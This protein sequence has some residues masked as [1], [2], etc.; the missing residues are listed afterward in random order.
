MPVSVAISLS[1]G[2]GVWQSCLSCSWLRRAAWG[3]LGKAGSGQ[4][5]PR[6]LKPPGCRAPSRGGQGA[7]E[8]PRVEE[9][10]V[11]TVSRK[12]PE[13]VP[14]AVAAADAGE[15]SLTWEGGCGSALPRPRTS[16]EPLATVHSRGPSP[17]LLPARPCGN[18][19]LVVPGSHPQPSWPWSPLPA[20]LL[21]GPQGT[22]RPVP[23]SPQ[24]RDGLATLC[25]WRCVSSIPN[26]PGG[27]AGHPGRSLGTRAPHTC[28]GARAAFLS[29]IF[30]L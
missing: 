13:L 4:G 5:P 20:C 25:A 1:F 24:H 30:F 27:E 8:G 18:L 7:A 11:L 10:L 9:S 29:F 3:P 12:G 14:V 19:P 2:P 6:A 28:P 22:A 23:F 16:T 17:R 15:R 21:R 26:G